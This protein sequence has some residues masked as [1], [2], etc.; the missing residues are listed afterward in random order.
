MDEYVGCKVDCN[1]KKGYMKLTQP[2]LLQSY[3]NKFSL[4][5]GGHAPHTPAKTGQVLSKGEYEKGDC[6]VSK[7]EHREYQTG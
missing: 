5:E 3:V 7:K 4:E 1:N 2:V 6:K